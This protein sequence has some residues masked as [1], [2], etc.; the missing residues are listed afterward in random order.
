MEMEEFKD[1]PEGPSSPGP[2]LGIDQ[3]RILSFRRLA[4][5]R[6]GGAGYQLRAARLDIGMGDRIAL[7][8][9]SGSGK[10][11]LLDMLA[12]ILKPDKADSFLW[13][14]G[15]SQSDL[16]KAWDGREKIGVE[17]LRRR[18][19][20]YVLQ[21][22]GLLPFL[23]LRDNIVLPALLKGSP[24]GK[25]LEEALL[26]LA[27]ELKIGH[28]LKKYPA[29]I[30]VGER[31]RVAIARAIIHRPSLI[32]ADEPTASLDPPTADRVFQLLLSLSGQAS[33]VVATHDIHRVKGLGF[34]ILRV[35]C[36]DMGPSQG[37]RA[38]LEEGL[39]A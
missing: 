11:T 21:T 13:R 36:Q 6:S 9:A 1:N 28:L 25:G 19:L 4:K 5:R 18:E 35:T 16:L 22:G 23:T 30:S 33:L 32:L 17:G 29:S 26:S 39:E 24:S 38:R 8:G 27:A 2:A 14:P 20:G 37:I 7:V 34:R 12:L 15:E 10:S 3:D 31:Q